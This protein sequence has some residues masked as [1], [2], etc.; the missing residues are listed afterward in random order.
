MQARQAKL[1]TATAWQESAAACVP[2]LA[3]NT[4]DSAQKEGM[5]ARRLASLGLNQEVTIKLS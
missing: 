2:F 4:L 1:P 5:R 3:L